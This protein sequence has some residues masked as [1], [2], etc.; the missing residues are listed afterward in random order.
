MKQ[1]KYLII[2][3]L[4]LAFKFLFLNLD[5]YSQSPELESSY[6]L[7]RDIYSESY[8]NYLSSKDA[9]LKQRT[10]ERKKILFRNLKTL[11]YSRNKLL[12]NYLEFLI[13]AIELNL[14]P[15]G[16]NK[17]RDWQIWLNKDEELINNVQDLE[18]A[19]QESNNL[20]EVYTEFEQDIFNQLYIYAVDNQQKVIDRVQLMKVKLKLITEN[21]DWVDEVELK[22]TNA[23]NYHQNAGLVLEE[24]RIRKPGDMEKAWN[25]AVEYLNNSQRE[26][27]I[28]LD[29]LDE[30]L[31]RQVE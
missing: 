16:I 14:E 3:I 6:I 7:S 19:Y 23:E 24:A 15:A 5:I 30:V 8:R 29:Y 27:N 17:L 13:N 2:I 21:T 12:H 22:L 10:L 4:I 18:T 25:K 11:L 20:V 31:K 9:Y 1:K 28:A 26:L